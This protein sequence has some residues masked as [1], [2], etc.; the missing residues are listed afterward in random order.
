M[1]GDD[2]WFKSIFSFVGIGSITAGFVS[3]VSI[4]AY[5]FYNL[6]LSGEWIPFKALFILRW[7]GVEWA[8]SPR[9]W[10]RVHEFLGIVPLSATLAALGVAIG[11]IAMRIGD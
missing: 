1:R 8:I 10:L 2:S 6:M 11:L 9:D 3:S 4:I 7:L 5:Q